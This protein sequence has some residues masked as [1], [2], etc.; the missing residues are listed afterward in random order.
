MYVEDGLGDANGEGIGEGIGVGN[1]D[2]IEDN[3]GAGIGVG[4][5]AGLT[6]IFGERVVVSKPTGWY[7]LF[8][9]EVITV[10]GAPESTIVTLKREPELKK[11][12]DEEGGVTGESDSETRDTWNLLLVGD[13]LA[14]GLGIGEGAGLLSRP[15]DRFGSFNSCREGSGGGIA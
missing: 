9:L 5:G 10:E 12:L 1:R 3:N 13:G 4:E 14:T 11:T 15:P 6:E 2:G 7:S 8:A